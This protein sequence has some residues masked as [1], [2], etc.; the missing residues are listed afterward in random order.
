MTTGP[1]LPQPQTLHPVHTRPCLQESS[2]IIIKYADDTTILGLIKAGDESGY[3]ALVN[4]IVVYGEENDL[5]LNTDKPRKTKELIL[6][7][8]PLQHLFI[9]GT[10]V[11][12]ADSYRFLG[13]QVKP[14][15]RWTHNTTATVKKAQQRLHFIRLLRKDGL[16]HRPLTQAYRGLIESILTA[17]ITVWYGNT[18][19]AEREALQRV[20]KTAEGIIGTKLPTMD[21]MY[22]QRCR[23]RAESIIETLSTPPHPPLR[24]KH[25]R[26]NLRLSRAERTA[27]VPTELD[28]SAAFSR[29]QSD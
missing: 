5:L 20:I 10:A 12:R 2:T 13:L 4:N 23:K 8:T 22:E 19:Q 21:T 14:E 17:G 27:S 26:Y 18:T 16:N 1:P 3:R 25:C 15:L 11:E 6:N 24:H 28:S 9:R 29:P 7:P